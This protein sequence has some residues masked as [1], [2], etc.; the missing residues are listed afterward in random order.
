MNVK[1]LVRKV[2]REISQLFRRPERMGAAK[3]SND[4][5]MR[6]ADAWLFLNNCEAAHTSWPIDWLWLPVMKIKEACHAYVFHRPHLSV[7]R[8]GRSI[9]G[10]PRFNFSDERK[11]P[12][13][14]L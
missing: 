14:K 1:P 2:F 13:C 9:G 4:N 6:W 12:N 11:Q 5:L 10:E 3:A 8:S 7:W